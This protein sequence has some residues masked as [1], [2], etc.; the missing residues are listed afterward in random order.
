M[1]SNRYKHGKA[2]NQ[3]QRYSADLSMHPSLSNATDSSS[4]I[5]TKIPL[6][7]ATTLKST[8]DPQPRHKSQIPSYVENRY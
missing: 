2:Q 5:S 4:D 3:Q 6:Q 1:R 7:N 8:D